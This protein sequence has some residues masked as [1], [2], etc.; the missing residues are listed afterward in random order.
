MLSY[1]KSGSLDEDSDNDGYDSRSAGTCAF[2]FCFAES[3]VCVGDYVGR[4][5]DSFG[6]VCG[7]GSGIFIL[8]VIESIGEVVP[9]A[10]FVPKGVESKGSRLIEIFWRLKS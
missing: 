5:D 2:P 3:V 8:T 10:V 6:R 7:M 4:V 9:L 1:D